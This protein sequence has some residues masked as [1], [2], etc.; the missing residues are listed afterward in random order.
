[1]KNSK[2]KISE[3]EKYSISTKSQNLIK[4][5]MPVIVETDPNWDPNNPQNGTGTPP[6]P[7]TTTMNSGTIK[8]E[9]PT[10]P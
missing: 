2:L 3:F 9:I 6:G 10:N 8:M 5:G 1:M 7:G 4:G